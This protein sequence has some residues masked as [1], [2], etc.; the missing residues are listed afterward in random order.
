MLGFFG[1]YPLLR[2]KFESSYQ[3]HHKNGKNN[4]RWVR[5]WDD[6]MEMVIRKKNDYNLGA[7]I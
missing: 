2:E 5:D 4:Y 7:I 6:E 3:Y 1:I